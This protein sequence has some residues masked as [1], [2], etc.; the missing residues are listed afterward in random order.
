MDLAGIPKSRRR[1]CRR[2]RTRGRR[3]GRSPSSCRRGA[4]SRGSTRAH[5]PG[6]GC[7]GPLLSPAAS[8]PTAAAW[9]P[10]GKTW[11][12]LSSCDASTSMGPDVRIR[13]RR[14][15]FRG[16][17]GSGV[18][19]WCCAAASGIRGHLGDFGTKL[20]WSLAAQ[21]WMRPSAAEVAANGAAGQCAG[22]LGL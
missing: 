10:S 20:R 1:G 16:S 7:C 19:V 6:A 22:P 18:G 3:P 2:C 21:G 12:L 5:A 17:G 8:W 14:F 9:P 4:G 13:K 15:P 11:S